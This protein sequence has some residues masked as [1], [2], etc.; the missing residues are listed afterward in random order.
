MR[1][2]DLGQTITILANLGVIAGI[3]F[4]GIELRQN[5]ELI[6]AQARYVRTERITGVARD[7]FAVPGRAEMIVKLGNGEALTEAEDYKLYM[8]NLM[9]LRGLESQWRDQV[10]GNLEINVAGMREAFRGNIFNA[11]MQNAWEQSKRSF[12]SEFVAWM[13]ENIVNER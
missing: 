10:E 1:N 6:E 11:P 2:L 8:F 4:L 13:E 9:R 3:V 5:N 12:P 7:M